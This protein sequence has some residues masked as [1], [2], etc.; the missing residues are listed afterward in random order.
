MF[1][2]PIVIF[3]RPR[4]E[5]NLGALARVM[6]NFGVT[7]LRIV[8]QVL[9][10]DASHELKKE[11]V[12]LDWALACKGKKILENLQSYPSLQEALSDIHWAL[13]TSARKR[14]EDCGYARP[15][16]FLKTS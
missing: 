4:A 9:K 8:G 5:G 11:D 16:G 7:N 6:S 14:E 10:L 13:G 1:K 15:V 3:V 2:A 12:P